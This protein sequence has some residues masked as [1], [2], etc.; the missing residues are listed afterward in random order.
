MEA[1]AAE[2][3]L[4][5]LS[6]PQS[7]MP[8]GYCNLIVVRADIRCGIHTRTNFVEL[9]RIAH[10]IWRSIDHWL[11]YGMAFLVPDLPRSYPAIRQ[12]EGGTTPYHERLLS[13]A[14]PI[15]PDWGTVGLSQT[16]A[17]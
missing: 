5:V 14:Y 9:L 17:N 16:P 4:C 10:C 8:A 12:P 3:Y 11:A 6:K 2:C 7:D 1:E 15:K 13:V